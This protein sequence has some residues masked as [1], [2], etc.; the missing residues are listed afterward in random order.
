M[1]K[2]DAAPAQELKVFHMDDSLNEAEGLDTTVDQEEGTLEVSAEHFS[3]FSA[4]LLT[5]TEV[6]KLE[7]AG[8]VDSPYQITSAND[9]VFMASKVNANAYGN[10]SSGQ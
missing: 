9:L 5:G 8:T 2:E 10:W 7:G 3:V 1:V 4:M 6:T